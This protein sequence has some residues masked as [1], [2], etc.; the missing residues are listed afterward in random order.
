VAVRSKRPV[1]EA[2]STGANA[3]PTSLPATINLPP[4]VMQPTSASAAAA[5]GRESISAA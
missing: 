4:A 1:N 5:I 2:A 3:A